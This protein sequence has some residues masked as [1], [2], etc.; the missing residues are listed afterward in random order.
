MNHVN[1]KT[2]V[3][4]VGHMEH[5]PILAR[6]SIASTMVKNIKPHSLK[7]W[8]AAHITANDDVVWNNKSRVHQN[9]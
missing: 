2:S 1:K 4:I 5:S 9:G 8:V 6:I 3:N 7:I